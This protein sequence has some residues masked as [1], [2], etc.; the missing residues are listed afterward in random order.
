MTIIITAS[1]DTFP[2]ADGLGGQTARATV[3]GVRS[4]ALYRTMDDPDPLILFAADGPDVAVGYVPGDETVLTTIDAS[5]LEAG[6]YTFARLVQTYGQYEIDARL[7]RLD[8]THDGVVSAFQVIGDGT[9][10]DGEIYDAGHYELVFT[11]PGVTE[12]WS[13]EDGAFPTYSSTAGAVGIVE[14]GEWAVYFPIDLEV[15]AVPT[16]DTTL[17]LDVN[18]HDGFRWTDLALL[19]Y[20]ANVFDATDIS[21]EPVVRFGGNAFDLTMR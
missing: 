19:G 9:E 10:V 3:A 12:E 16:A 18:M 2:H 11:A 13:G 15:D 14:G 6:S 21:F 20:E 5:A 8:G 1:G 17:T 7:H 4:F